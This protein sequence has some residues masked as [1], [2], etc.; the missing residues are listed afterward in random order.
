MLNSVDLSKTITK[1][2]YEKQLPIL[3]N[4]LLKWQR[5]AYQKG[6]PIIIT[7]EGWDAA[8]K[9]GNIKRLTAKLDPRIFRVIP[10]AK[11]S[12]E[13]FAHHYLWRFWK[14]IPK[15]GQI[16]IFD[17][18]WYG[19]VL[20]ERVE[21]FASEKEWKQAFQEINEFERQLTDFGT[22]VVK[23]WIHISKEEQL[24]RFEERQANKYKVW[25]ITDED[26]RNREKWDAYTVALNEIFQKTSTPNAPWTI[27]EGNSKYYARLKAIKTVT[28]AIK[29]ALRS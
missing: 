20:V 21:G 1:A 8:G 29:E 11:P 28:K 3:Q 23:F 5:K 14:K 17:R 27:I 25:K 2:E 4:K 7:Y 16:A 10:I 15:K 9:G 19:R 13:E 18:T 22:I 6:R 12:K 24:Q 26:W